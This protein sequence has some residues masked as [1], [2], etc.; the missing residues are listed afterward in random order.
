LSQDVTITAKGQYPVSIIDDL[1]DELHGSSWF[2]S[3]DLCFRFHQIAMNQE[4][5]FK[6]VFQTHH[7]HY[8][9]MVMSFGLIGAPHTFQKA[10]NSTLEP[11]LRSCDLVFFDDIRVYSKSLA[12]H[13]SHLEQDKWK[14]KL[15]KCTFA[16]R[17]ITY[18][19][20][21]I[22]E[23]RV[24]TC[25]EKVQAISCWPV[26]TNVKELRSFFGIGRLL[27]EICKALWND[28]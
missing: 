18:L 23:Q 21:V 12:D 14:A 7:E 6:T 13:R 15:S 10:M 27:Q 20:Y 9:F 3:L 24:S 8:E 19:G 2:S 11:L 28:I 1:L 22:N 25:P 26:P 17:Q 4:D 5:H 16:A